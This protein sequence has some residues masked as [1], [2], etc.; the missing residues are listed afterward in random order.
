LAISVLF[1]EVIFPND[2]EWP[3]AV[4]AGLTALGALPGSSLARRWTDRSHA[5]PPVSG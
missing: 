2:A 5:Q 4:N 3:L 1:T